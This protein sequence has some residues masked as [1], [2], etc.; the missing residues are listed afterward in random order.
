MEKKQSVLEPIETRNLI[1]RDFSIDDKSD[2]YYLYSDPEVMRLDQSEPI[3]DLVEAKTLIKNFQQSNQSHNSI[4][5]GVEL[6]ETKKV[7]GTCGFK[8]WNRL[9]HHAEI[10]GN[11]LS[12]EW[13]K[14]Y[15]KETLMFL[16]EYGFTKMYLNKIYAYTNVKNRIVLT[17][18][19]K[20]GFQQEGVLREHQ[21]LGREFYDVLVFSL[22]K[23][24]SKFDSENNFSNFIG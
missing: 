24:E 3:K 9:S 16:I 8:N 1:F 10:G 15:G 7:I 17:L 11:I 5:W 20:Y 13:G 4:S 12:K 2:I 21:L 19:N 6:K 22:L 14:G 23:K 18:M